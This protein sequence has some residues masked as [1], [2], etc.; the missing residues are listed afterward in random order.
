MNLSMNWLKDF[1]DT[2]GI[3]TKTFSDE[4][5]MSGSKVE[6]FEKLGEEIENVVL[7]EVKALEKHPDSDHL[8]ICQIDDGEE[9]LRQIVTGAQNL[10]VGAL[11][12]VAKA[13]A[14]LPG[15]IT[16]KAGKLRGIDSNGMLC[17]IGELGLT[18]NDMPG[19]NNDGIF[20]LNDYIENYKMGD[21]V[22]EL[23]MLSD[24]CVE[25]EITSNRP[26]CLSVIGLA[27]EAAVTFGRKLTL[28]DPVVTEKDGCISE[29]LS[30]E[31]DEPALCPRYMA[32]V[33]KNVRI[34]PSPLWLRMRLRAS[35]VR[36]INNIVDI[37]NYVMLEYGQP[38][39][40]FDYAMLE[41]KEIVVRLAKEGENFK[42]LD[43]KDHVL[44]STNLVISDAKKAV[45]LAGVMGGAN[46]EI[47]DGTSVVVFESANFNGASVRL[48]AKSQGM[49]TESSGRFE[50]G[51]D[52]ENCKK[53]LD[54]ALELVTLLDA[55]DVVCGEID[56]YKTRPEKVVVNT[57]AA[58]I[59][60]FLGTNVAADR[61]VE[62]FEQLEVA[63]ERNGDEFTLTAPSFRSDLACMPDYAEEIAR[64]YG[65]NNIES[66]PFKGNVAV[67]ALTEKQA[68]KARL[69]KTLCAMGLTQ[70]IT[71]SFVSPKDLDKIALAKDDARRNQLVISNPLGEDTS[72][73][74]TTLIP[75]LLGVLAHNNNHHSDGA[76]MYE[77]AHVYIP[78]ED[79]EQL[80]AEPLSLALGF[81]GK[82]DFYDLKGIVEN[83]LDQFG[84]IKPKFA[85]N[86]E[87]PTY[88]P[89]R[90]AD[91]IVRGNKVIAT[92]GQIHPKVATAYGFNS[93]VY[94]ADIDV[95]KLF[96]FANVE[97][98]YKPLPKFPTT[99]RDYA[100][101]VDR[102]LEAGA[103][104]DVI[105][106]AGGKLVEDVA[107]FDVYK[108]DKI[109]ADKK[110]MAFRVT[111]RA[112][113]H[114][115]TVDEAE[116]ISEKILA[117]L[118]KQ[119]GIALRG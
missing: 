71:F 17:S 44:K 100:F 86:S 79:P 109:P 119:L 1:V 47:K 3:D 36:P 10:F 72:V 77:L 31:V 69:H 45:A 90:C 9:A 104:E 34:A 46:S 116:K 30:V 58:K 50:K 39:H 103:I 61:M 51:L 110:S 35:G 28:K 22:K 42:S 85:S 27:R 37:T 32:R 89:G 21:D 64:I 12:P 40:A 25:F 19:S 6:G 55:G 65:Y 87:N 66:T 73:M 60:S 26:D 43:D 7:G 48:T 93:P 33:V 70:S 24:D 98:H 112:Q 5:T 56:V 92:I 41:G 14:K 16:I 59:N 99:T 68:Y 94:I 2:T 82:G 102:S 4:M 107:L 118:A 81:Y 57:T 101:L 13:P 75:G 74:R 106:R 115:L 91:V 54:R 49:R 18:E 53:A 108:G 97:K 80:P 67:G 62:I 88:H 78:N 114:T 113:D 8:W 23:L 20:I 63:V 52:P 111:M 105:R 29:Y 11:V 96:N 84:I 117:A 38:M 76:A 95:E 15:G 83:I